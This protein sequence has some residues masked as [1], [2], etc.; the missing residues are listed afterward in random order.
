MTRD[1]ST[2][3][4]T[5]AVM[6]V[7][8]PSSHRFT[9]GDD[10]VVLLKDSLRD[11]VWP[12]GSV[13]LESGDIVTISSKVVAKT[14]G[15]VH[16]AAEREDW[17]KADTARI[18]ATKVTPQG[19]TQIVQTHQGFV[20]AAAGVD[21]SNTEAGTIVRLPENPDASAAH[22]RA[23]IAS[24]MSIDVGVI[25]TDTWGRAWRMG[26]TDHAI[27]SSGVKVLDDYADRVDGFGR[28]L[29]TTVIALAD[30]IAAFAHLA[31]PKEQLVPVVAVRGLSHYVGETH[32][33]ALDLIRPPDQDLFSLGT[34]EAWEKG[35]TSAINKRR[36][37]RAFRDEP[38]SQECIHAVI[39]DALTAPAPHHTKPWR[40]LVLP[41]GDR[42]DSILNAMSERWRED[43]QNTPSVDPASIE[44][45]I[46][47]GDIL[48][49]A[50]MVIMPF[51]HLDSGAHTYPDETRT[52]Y[53][54]DMFMVSGGAAIENLMISAAVRGLGTAWISSSLFCPDV[55]RNA[56]DLDD[57]WHPLGSVAMGYPADEPT[58]RDAPHV[59][60]FLLP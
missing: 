1:A 41:L 53:E 6:A 33:R 17:I 51:V 49:R 4:P 7:G 29:R 38:V 35:L 27:G 19:T 42:R 3:S 12:D 43:L 50:P 31:A 59:D 54:R 20:L 39:A 44:A 11:V 5:H 37:V 24:L 16:D 36:T 52:A 22:I 26:V 60:A 9:T 10:I 15:R 32:D 40:F 25:I 30:E 56:L 14:E 28:P 47:R 48:R 45:R 23:K 21:E 34:L 55:V 46:R 13:G 18:V 57:T 58:P 2:S 8:V